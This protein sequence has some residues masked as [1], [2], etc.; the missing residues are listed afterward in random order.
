MADVILT[1]PLGRDITLHDRTWYGHIIKR[2][3]EMRALRA[4][5]EQTVRDPDEI[6]FSTYDPDCRLYYRGSG[7]AGILIAVVGD[8]AQE[9]VRTACLANRTKGALEWSRPT[10]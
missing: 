8:V 4:Q 7:R 1:D 10:P 2:H 9:L 5:V 6:R 3:P